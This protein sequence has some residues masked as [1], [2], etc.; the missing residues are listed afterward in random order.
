[1]NKFRIVVV[2][3][4]VEKYIIKCINS[5]IEQ[6]FKNWTLCA[7]LDP[8]NDNTFE[9]VKIFSDDRIK[10]IYNENQQYALLNIIKSIKEQNPEDE[11]IIVTVDGD[12]WL[13]SAQTL[14]IVDRYYNNNPELIVTHGSWVPYPN[15][16]AITNNSPYTLSDF[17]NNIRKVAWRASHLRTFKYKAWKRIKDND[18]RDHEGKYYRSAWDLAIMWPILEM[19][20]FN[21]TKFISEPLYVYNQENPYGD[22]FMRLQEQMRYTDYIARMK[23]YDPI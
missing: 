21:R 4:N 9:V 14:S 13:Y 19:A 22:T 6:D 5:I 20:T 15:S 18:F 10:I 23:P 3:W 1:M 12:D 11:D 8:S 17:K 2:G 16:H 7:V